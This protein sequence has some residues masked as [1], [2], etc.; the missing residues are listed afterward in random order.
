[1]SITFSLGWGH[2]NEEVKMLRRRL[3]AALAAVAMLA[4]RHLKPIA[5][6]IGLAVPAKSA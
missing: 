1:M 5:P 2:P 4:G 3:F 6:G